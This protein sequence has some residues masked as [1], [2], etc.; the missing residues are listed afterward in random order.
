M[1][2]QALILP[3]PEQM[4]ST[5]EKSLFTGGFCVPHL[6]ALIRFY[7]WLR[8]NLA[9]KE[10]AGIIWFILRACLSEVFNV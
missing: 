3:L 9:R 8:L 6:V 5:G 7:R 1:H 10:E 2:F 4:I